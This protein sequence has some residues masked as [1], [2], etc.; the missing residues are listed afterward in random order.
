MRYQL[1]VHHAFLQHHKDLHVGYGASVAQAILGL[2]RGHWVSMPQALGT[3]LSH[4]GTQPSFSDVKK[5]N[6]V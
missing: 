2:C 1:S 5:R 4:H 6:I 3:A